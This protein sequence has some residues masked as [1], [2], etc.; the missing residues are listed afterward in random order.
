MSTKSSWVTLKKFSLTKIGIILSVNALPFFFNT[1]N[2]KPLFA[3]VDPDASQLVPAYVSELTL[4]RSVVCHLPL[5]PMS[6][7]TL[8][9]IYTPTPFPYRGLPYLSYVKT[10]FTRAAHNSGKIGWCIPS[11]EEDHVERGLRIWVPLVRERFS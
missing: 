8:R 2:V 11:F 5:V 3:N 7:F 6:M 1:L 4:H 9:G 10:G